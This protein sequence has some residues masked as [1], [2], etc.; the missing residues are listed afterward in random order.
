[1]NEVKI[2]KLYKKIA[3]DKTKWQKD[4]LSFHFDVHFM[5]IYFFVHKYCLL[6]LTLENTIVCR[7]CWGEMY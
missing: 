3:N 7:V 5:K 4:F 6:I 1:M 2:R